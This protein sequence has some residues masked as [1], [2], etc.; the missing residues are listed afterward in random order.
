MQSSGFL[1]QFQS[2][3]GG[4]SFSEGE[5][6]SI[7]LR[8]GGWLPSGKRGP[9]APHLEPEHKAWFTLGLLV[10]G[11]VSQ[12]CEAVQAYGGLAADG[13]L[14]R[15]DANIVFNALRLIFGDRTAAGDVAELVILQNRPR[16]ELVLRGGRVFGFGPAESA[17]RLRSSVSLSG[18]VLRALALDGFRAAWD[19]V[20]PGEKITVPVGVLEYDDGRTEV[21]SV[22]DGEALVAAGL[23][24]ADQ[25]AV[26]PVK[27]PAAKPK[28]ASSKRKVKA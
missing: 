12:V 9:G 17:F 23:A 20:L 2:L 27:A 19:P 4:Q 22:E 28:R 7:L 3:T 6:R 11:T 5:A 25:V 26:G 8:A 14:W 24:D 15:P 1:Q 13:E 21:V 16:V 10:P 18:A